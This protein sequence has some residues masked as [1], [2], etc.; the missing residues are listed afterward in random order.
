MFE[1]NSASGDEVIVLKN[2][3]G[4]IKLAFSTGAS[5]VPCYLFGNT[6]LF[7][8]YTGGSL[9]GFFRNISRKIGTF[10]EE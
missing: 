3:K 7:S 4:I 9:H 10:D 1:T 6:H 2:R 5:L 8:L